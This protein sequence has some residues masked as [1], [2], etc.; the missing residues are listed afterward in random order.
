ML[1]V[2][3]DGKREI[4]GTTENVS[5]IGVLMSTD[6]DISPGTHVELVMAIV[7]PATPP[8]KL[9]L[10]NSGRVVRVEMRTENSY[11]IAIECDQPFEEVTSSQS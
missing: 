3:Q 1:E 8:Y 2:P 11:A 6:T 9:R 4:H 5:L 10:S 7:Q